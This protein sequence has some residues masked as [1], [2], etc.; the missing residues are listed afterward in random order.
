MPVDWKYLPTSDPATATLSTSVTGL[1][2]SD[3]GVPEGSPMP[4]GEYCALFLIM[5]GFVRKGRISGT[6]LSIVP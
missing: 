5:D 4:D 1:L 2:A 6:L 3:W